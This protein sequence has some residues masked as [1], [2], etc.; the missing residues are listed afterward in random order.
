MEWQF[1]SS[2]IPTT[3]KKK[4]KKVPKNT[5]IYPNLPVEVFFPLSYFFHPLKD[6][7]VYIR[8]CVCVSVC[9]YSFLTPPPSVADE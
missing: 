3:L 6:I 8:V 2:T 5:I 1:T 4:K 9:K 7:C